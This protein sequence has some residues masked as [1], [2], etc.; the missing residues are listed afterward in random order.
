MKIGLIEVSHWHS[1][2]YIDALVALGENIVAV[3]DRNELLAKRVADKVKCRYY[4]DYR[5]MLEREDL[6]FVFSF[7][8]H[9]DMPDI[10]ES[11]IDREIPFNTEKPCG[12]DYKT[13]E[14]L[15]EKASEK[16]LFTSV[17]FVKRISIKVQE[18]LDSLNKIGEVKYMYFK[19]ITGPPSRY[20]EWKCPWML[21]KKLAGG[22]CLINLGVHYI[23][24]VH[25]LTREEAEVKYSLILNKVYELSVE[26]YALVV[27]KTSK[28][29]SVVEVAYT[30]CHKSEEYFSIIGTSGRIILSEKKLIKCFGKQKEVIDV[31]ENEYFK[32]VEET[33][34]RFKGRDKPIASLEDAA[35]VL[36]VVN[37]AYSRALPNTS[38]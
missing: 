30:P 25:Y 33:I 12:I 31:K 21:D 2:M 1:G 27:L 11:L 13:V 14:K 28:T 24:L 6:D 34:N 32:F 3:S 20:I 29:Y 35:K 4:T 15:T 9:V 22:G 38:N 10:I 23:D 37:E 36:K 7:G 26:E 18:I 19:Y 5:E 8:R 16:K 17:S